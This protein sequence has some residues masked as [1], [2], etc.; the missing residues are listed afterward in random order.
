MGFV[1]RYNNRADSQTNGRARNGPGSS[2]TASADMTIKKELPSA[3]AS[4]KHQASG[5]FDDG[6][7]EP[8]PNQHRER[9]AAGHGSGVQAEATLQSHETQELPAIKKETKEPKAVV[10]I[11]SSPP[12]CEGRVTRIWKR[13][14]PPTQNQRQTIVHAS[15]KDVDDSQPVRTQLAKGKQ[16]RQAGVTGVHGWALPHGKASYRRAPEG[17][18]SRQQYNDLMKQNQELTKN[19]RE[20]SKKSKAVIENLEGHVA[21]TR[22]KL[23]STNAILETKD[24]LHEKHI[25]RLRQIMGNRTRQVERLQGENVELAKNLENCKDRIFNMQPV[26]GMADTQLRD[27]YTQ[28]CNGVEYWVE[29]HFSEVDSLI[30]RISVAEDTEP[31]NIAKVHLMPEDA[32]VVQQN[33][34][35]ELAMLQSLISRHLFSNLLAPQRIF[36]GLDEN[37]EF[38][39]SEIFEGMRLLKPAKGRRL[40]SPPRLN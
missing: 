15:P 32:E 20:E 14:I 3:L 11:T 31:T 21:R 17:G 40:I 1:P 16:Q 9:R 10:E 4:G 19:F 8:P 25:A 35:I 6:E 36:P 33:P 5:F 7:I 39:L 2:S 22:D 12:V 18:V 37:A 34:D 23:Q 29:N 13:F 26:E 38:W 28:V 27:N 24:Q 30:L